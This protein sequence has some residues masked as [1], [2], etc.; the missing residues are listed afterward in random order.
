M[1][2]RHGVVFCRR[3]A[4]YVSV[5][6]CGMCRRWSAGAHTSAHSDG[7]VTIT[8]G[9]EAVAWCRGQKWTER[10]FCEQCGTSLFLRLE[11]QPKLFT[12][13][14]VDALNFSFQHH[15][16]TD[17]QPNCYSLPDDQQ[18]VTGVELIK[19]FGVYAAVTQHTFLTAHL[20]GADR[21]QN[22]CRCGRRVAKPGHRP[23]RQ[24]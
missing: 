18:R 21:H 1:P 16:Y 12:V 4:R 5:S 20:R 13:I 23:A 11:N 7:L 8:R 3:A 24:P 22:V 6:H 17:A 14:A 9:A 10:G 2:L 15:I 19:K